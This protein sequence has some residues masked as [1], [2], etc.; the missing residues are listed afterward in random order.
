[1][2][3][4]SLIAGARTAARLEKAQR[5]VNTEVARLARE[6]QVTMYYDRLARVTITPSNMVTKRYIGFGGIMMA[7]P[8]IHPIWQWVKDAPNVRE[9]LP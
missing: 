6:S 1:M 3:L 4:D 5:L 7:V 2:A 8:T 9:V